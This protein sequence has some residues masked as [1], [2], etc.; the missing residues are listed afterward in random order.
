MKRTLITGITYFCTDKFGNVYQR[1]SRLHV[2]EPT[3]L[4][5]C[6]ERREGTTNAVGKSAVQYSRSRQN[7]INAANRVL[8]C[9]YY[10]HINRVTTPAETEVVPVRAYPGRHT[11][12]PVAETQEA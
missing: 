9:G 12:E 2:G 1:Y 5:A 3:Y 11:V 8:R 10:D 7:A 6:I 4:W